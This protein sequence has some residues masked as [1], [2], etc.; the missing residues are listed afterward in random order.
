MILFYW[1]I[2][3]F[4][5]QIIYYKSEFI[6]S[7][8]LDNTLLDPENKILIMK[9]TLFICKL[10]IPVRPNFKNLKWYPNQQKELIPNSAADMH[11][12]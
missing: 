6:S 9:L 1:K 5:V 3:Y 10:I 12:A 2:I 7:K 8:W 11:L 4:L